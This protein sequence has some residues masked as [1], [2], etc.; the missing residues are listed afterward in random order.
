MKTRPVRLASILPPS[1]FTSDPLNEETV[2]MLMESI[3]AIGLI[4]P[5]TVQMRHWRVHLV[6]GR[7]RFEAAKRLKWTEIQAVELPSTDPQVDN[8]DLA[9]MAEIAE[10]LHRREITALERSKLRAQWLEVT[11]KN[12]PR[13]VGA[14]SEA[15]GRGNKGGVK[16]AARDLSIPE[17]SLRRD[18]KIASLSPEAQ[19]AAKASGLDNNQSALL[20]AAKH[21]EPEQQV[22]AIRQRAEAAPR[23]EPTE[24]P[25][26]IRIREAWGAASKGSRSAFL[27]EIGVNSQRGSA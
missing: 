13:Q 9:A 26:L 14:V 4:N 17:G 15:G 3:K 21:R 1:Q 23:P 27:T 5:I 25:D 16:Q 8:S 18:I 20:A 22:E 7:H 12:K 11:S 24:P 19:E 10:N 2:L 6:A